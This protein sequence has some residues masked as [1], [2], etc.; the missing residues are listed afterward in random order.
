[1]QLQNKGSHVVKCSGPVFSFDKYLCYVLI[2]LES[3]DDGTMAHF[4][5]PIWGQWNVIH[6]VVQHPRPAFTEGPTHLDVL[7]DFWK[8]PR[9]T[10]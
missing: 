10:T 1:M 2:L 8:H 9:C 3:V 5:H 7:E 6:R 4:V